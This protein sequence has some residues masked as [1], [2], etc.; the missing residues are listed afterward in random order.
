MTSLPELYPVVEAP[1]Y[2]NK[3]SWPWPIADIEPGTFVRLSGQM[4]SL[5]VG[6][7]MAQLV[8]YNQIKAETRTENL[9]QSLMAK[10]TLVLPG[11]LQAS[12][13]AKSINPG[14]CCGLETWRESLQVILSGQSPWMGHDPSPWIEWAGSIVRVWSD[15]AHWDVCEPWSIEFQKDGF[16]TQLKGIENKL[17][18]FYPLILAWAKDVGFSSPET[19][20][21]KIDACFHLNNPEFEQE[22]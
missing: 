19:L 12:F 3:T 1:Y 6:S 9:L 22:N 21:D 8:S 4:T 14:C 13:N 2:E 20:G 15:G 11:F 17:I 7:V 16:L 5:E 18:D 10:E